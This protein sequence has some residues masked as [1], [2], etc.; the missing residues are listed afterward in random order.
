MTRRRLAI[1][2]AIT[3]LTFVADAGIGTAR[4]QTPLQATENVTHYQNRD[5]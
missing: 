5:H 3:L 2:A 1:A 4:A